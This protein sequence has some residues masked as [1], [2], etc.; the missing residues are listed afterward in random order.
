MSNTNPFENSGSD[1]PVKTPLD[2]VR[3]QVGTY[4]DVVES[5][6]PEKKWL[7]LPKA[8]DPK[9]FKLGA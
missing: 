3:Q 1:K 6:P 5:T 9:P 7:N 8:P 4:N 2:A